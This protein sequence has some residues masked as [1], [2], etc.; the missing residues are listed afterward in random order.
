MRMCQVVVHLIE[1]NIDRRLPGY[2]RYDKMRVRQ[3]TTE[4]YPRAG[5]PDEL[6]SIF[7]TDDVLPP[8]VTVA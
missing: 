1:T 8:E 6:M 5:I 7:E 2:V 4:L 3:R